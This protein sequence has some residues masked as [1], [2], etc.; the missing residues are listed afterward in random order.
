MSRLYSQ[1]GRICFDLETSL[2]QIRDR[3]TLENTEKIKTE[4]LADVE[5]RHKLI[6]ENVL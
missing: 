5:L 4:I 6:A 1:V 3:V 2:I